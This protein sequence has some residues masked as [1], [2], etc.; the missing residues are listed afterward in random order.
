VESLKVLYTAGASPDM[1][2]LIAEDAGF[3]KKHGLKVDFVNSPQPIQPLI[4]GDVDVALPAP[5]VAALTF[6]QGQSVKILMTEDA[7]ISMWLMVR[8]DLAKTFKAQAGQYPDVVRELAGKKLGV[9]VRGGLVDLAARYLVTV[10]GLRPDKDIAI[11]PTGSVANLGAAM[12]S[13]QVDAILTGSPLSF[14]LVGN[15][16]ATKV[17][18][19]TAGEGPLGLQQPFVVA[20]TTDKVISQKKEALK[21]FV[22]AMTDMFT[23]AHD[24]KNRDTVK[25]I[26]VNR[27]QGF[28]PAVVDPA[29]DELIAAMSPVFSDEDLKKVTEVLSVNGLLTKPVHSQDIF[30]PALMPPTRA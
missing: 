1:P 12:Q 16:D 6:L 23:W 28:N 20:A 30:S 19:I 29:V 25:K 17:L 4:S 26:L 10:A 13:K 7:K 5:T 9:T 14:Q 15:G 22:A 2:V 3:Y 11:V 18:D 24:P 21:R 27:L 8:P